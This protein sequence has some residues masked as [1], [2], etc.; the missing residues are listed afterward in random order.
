MKFFKKVKE[1]RSRKGEL[2]FQRYAIVE[3]D[4]FAVYIHKIYK[5]DQDAHLHDHPWNFI[6]MVLGGEYYELHSDKEGGEFT[7]RRPFVPKL[8]KATEYYHK[9]ASIAKGPVTTLV[10]R[11]RRI[12]DWGYRTSEGFIEASEYR[13]RKINGNLPRA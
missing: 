11:G 6:G 4:A 9:I 13:L 12:H 3:C 1:I 7:L 5:R 2:H 10:I 8:I